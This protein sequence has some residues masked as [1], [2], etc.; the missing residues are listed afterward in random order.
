[1]GFSHCCGFNL[2]AFL[3][4]LGCLI[5]G[6]RLSVDCVAEKIIATSQIFPHSRSE[7]DSWQGWNPQLEFSL[8]LD[9]FSVTRLEELLC[10]SE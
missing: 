2:I 4:V 8:R 6:S 5:D 1:M 10:A 3:P 9:K 7:T